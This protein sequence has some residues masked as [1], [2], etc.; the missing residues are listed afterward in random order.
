MAKRRQA[1]SISIL[2]AMTLFM[3]A[4][5]GCNG[6]ALSNRNLREKPTKENP[7]DARSDLGSGQ[8]A[9]PETPGDKDSTDTMEVTLYF[10][11]AQAEKL[12]KEIRSVPRTTAVAK[13]AVEELIKGPNEGGVATIPNGTRLI[14]L[15]VSEG[16]AEVNL[17]KEIVD[18]HTGGS[19]GERLTVYSIVDT[20]TEFSS[21][22]EVRLLVEGVNV[23][24]IA[25]H[26]DLSEP[27]KRDDS[28]L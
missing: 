22:S 19:A 26:M 5:V 8:V 11:D 24:T 4:L 13:T 1:R 27:L 28:L 25:G 10:S 6:K 7:S 15:T 21:I 2:A 23:D 9:N 18:N 3:L 20:L 12:V 14:G 17:S 16:L